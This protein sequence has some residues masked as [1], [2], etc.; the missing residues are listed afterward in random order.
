MNKKKKSNF[1]KW[2]VTLS[3]IF[4]FFIASVY[5]VWEPLSQIINADDNEIGDVGDGSITDPGDVWVEGEIEL[6]WP[7]SIDE[8]KMDKS[9]IDYDGSIDEGIATKILI[10]DLLDNMDYRLEYSDFNVEVSY[11]STDIVTF[12]VLVNNYIE[13]KEK[14]YKLI[15]IEHSYTFLIKGI[16]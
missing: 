16:K 15:N 3:L 2:F 7:A 1:W 12:D 8:N 13:Y 6:S 11:Q 5:T 10:N 9:I 14:K 4:S